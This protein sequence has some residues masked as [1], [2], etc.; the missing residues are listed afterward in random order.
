MSAEKL[1]E[2]YVHIYSFQGLECGPPF[3]ASYLVTASSPY[4]WRETFYR[5]S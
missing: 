4:L 5:I 3:N 2:S 1:L